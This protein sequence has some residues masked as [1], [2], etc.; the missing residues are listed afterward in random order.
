MEI[1]VLI[2][3]AV[4]S[5]MPTAA[6]GILGFALRRSGDLSGL[7]ASKEATEK[8]MTTVLA[9]LKEE[10]DKRDALEQIVFELPGEVR[11]EFLQ[12]EDHVRHCGQTDKQFDTIWRELELLKTRIPPPHPDR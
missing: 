6:I 8:Q 9:Q 3:G 5:A 4:I 10:R 11:K 2:L 12:R 7:L 1:E